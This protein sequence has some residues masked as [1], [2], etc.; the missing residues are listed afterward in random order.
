MDL[1][2][3]SPV[4]MKL[5]ISRSN[6]DA[7]LA[8]VSGAIP[9]RSAL[10]VLSNVLLETTRNGIRISSTDLDAWIRAEAPAEVRKQGRTTMPGATLRNIVANLEP[11]TVDLKVADDRLE[12]SCG[13]TESTLYGMPAE[14]YPSP[15]SVDF[16]SAWRLE[17][18]SLVELINR[19]AFA[20]ST[21]ETRPLL[22]GVYWEL[23]DGSM[24]MVATDGHRLAAYAKA[25]ELG[26]DL[27]AD[28]IVPTLALRSVQNL[29]G[30]SGVVE[31]A[32][33]Q[34]YLAFR[35]DRIEVFTRL[36]EGRYPNYRQ[37]IPAERSHSANVATRDLATAIARLLPL[38]SDTKR[39]RVNFRSGRLVADAHSP[40]V[41]KGMDE[42]DID[43]EGDDMAIGFNAHYLKEAL[44]HLP[45]EEAVV[46]FENPESAVVLRPRAAEGEEPPDYLSLV[47]PLRLLD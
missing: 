11:S 13:R 15:P 12:L 23:S 24:R 20:V 41:G 22:N 16:G 34:N 31:V 5:S 14:D 9:A 17:R 18:D 30:E 7:C 27:T 3:P 21:E 19:T 6:L 43:Y 10:P 42:I 40:D 36:I 33:T 39:M 2:P 26:S 8:R 1:S 47:M 35:M 46:D 38:T 44:T 4:F 28:M 37:V 32:R 45:A 29:F 25:T